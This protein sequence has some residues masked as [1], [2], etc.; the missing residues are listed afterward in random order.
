MRILAVDDAGPAQLAGLHSGDVLVPTGN[1][2][3][4][5]APFFLFANAPLVA[6]GD[7][8]RVTAQ[9]NGR[10]KDVTLVARANPS[11]LSYEA[12]FF[13]LLATPMLLL[14]WLLLWRKAESGDAVTLG[15]MLLLFGLF[16][17]APDRVGS[18]LDRFAISEIFAS[19][20]IIAAVMVA[21]IFFARY[22]EGLGIRRSRFR[23]ALMRLAIAVSIVE[24]GLMA[25][26]YIGPAYVGSIT[27]LL[28]PT[29]IVVAGPIL[30]AL[31]CFINA[32]RFGDQTERARLRWLGGAYFL[33]FTGPI[34]I[35]PTSLLLGPRFTVVDQVAFESTLF[36]L[37]FGLTYAVLRRRVVDITFVLNRAL[38]FSAVSA[39]VVALFIGIEWLTGLLFLNISRSTSF[40]LEAGIAVAIGFSL[41][42]IH[43]QVDRFIDRVFFAKR[44]AA[45][46]ALHH[47]AAEVNFI[48]D[49]GALTGRVQ[50]DLST[51][52]DVPLVSIYYRDDVQSDFSLIGSTEN[53]AEFID[54]DD[55][56]VVALTVQEQP[57]ELHGR[58][59]SLN[60]ELA[61]PLA[62]RK[63]LVG[64][65]VL[66]ERPSHEAYAPDEI[67][68][69][70]FL[71]NNL[72]PSLAVKAAPENALRTSIL[73]EILA[74]LRLQRKELKALGTRI[75]ARDE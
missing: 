51:Y 72:A 32:F 17:A 9:H 61:I 57:I 23:L 74:E 21:A 58:S 41:R 30:A 70:R 37:A 59:T 65:L 35:P 62:V 28:I 15:I 31:L 33:G 7:A 19:A 11:G 1:A 26:S 73:T 36:I 2:L 52:L 44:H 53:T 22:P 3:T 49:R 67:E 69:L 56:A 14:G 18:P 75:G 20:N 55:D 46:R 12:L 54:A 38:V 42:P 50:R 40:L 64:M 45:E 16:I 71:A 27:W 4:E 63:A 60:G 68:S 25:F 5:R 10:S 48:R 24:L 47:L 13:C 39:I 34:L 66:G 6:R 29:V 43:K 8:V